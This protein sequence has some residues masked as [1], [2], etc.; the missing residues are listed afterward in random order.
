MAEYKGMYEQRREVGMDVKEKV[1]KYRTE[2]AKWINCER[3]ENH[4]QMVDVADDIVHLKI[5]HM[6]NSC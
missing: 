2:S 4:V 3:E 5:W 6:H 1:L